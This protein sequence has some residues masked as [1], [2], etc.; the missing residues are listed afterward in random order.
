MAKS[1]TNLIE[2][3]YSVVEQDPEEGMVLAGD[4]KPVWLSMMYD[5]D[6]WEGSEQDE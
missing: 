3:P 1:K 2:L 6:N 5:L 4:I